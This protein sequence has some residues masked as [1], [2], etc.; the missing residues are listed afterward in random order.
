MTNPYP[1]QDGETDPKTC[2]ELW[3]TQDDADA[4]YVALKR[5]ADQLKIAVDTSKLQALYNQNKDKGQSKYTSDS[6]KVF[7]KA[8]KEASDVLANQDASQ[9]DVDNAYQTLSNAVKQLKLKTSQPIIDTGD[10]NSNQNSGQSSDKVNTNDAMM[11]APYAILAVCAAGAY[12]T[13]KR[14]RV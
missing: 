6:W 7:D 14:K 12:V 8:L 9:E 11:F 13:I 1:L 4:A 3:G 10:K 2:I 5:A